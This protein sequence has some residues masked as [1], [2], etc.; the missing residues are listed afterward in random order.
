M[1]NY[2]DLEAEL[3]T[4]FVHPGGATA[5]GFLLSALE[6]A[7]GDIALDL[8]CGSGATGREAAR[9]GLEVIGL[10]L[11]PAMLAAAR[12][13]T[14]TQKLVLADVVEGLPFADAVFDL[15]WTESVAAIVDPHV[16]LPEMTR[17][18]RPGGRIALNERVWRSGVGPA[19]AG[20]INT[21]SRRC[22]GI[23]AA[24]VDPGDGAEWAALLER[25]GIRLESVTAVRRL[26]HRPPK[27]TLGQWTKRQRRY[28][29]SPAMFSRSLRWRW[30]IRRHRQSWQQLESWIFVGVRKP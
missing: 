11:R 26:A 21:L 29:S 13:R 7:A 9:M 5:T 2:L 6:P 23:P 15:V 19:E 28:L 22:F 24:A 16:V 3:A 8:G 14:E 18:V 10:D 17:V 30:L 1:I 20:R 25:H 12:R 4:P 27:S